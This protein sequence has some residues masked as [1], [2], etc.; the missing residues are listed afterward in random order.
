MCPLA[1]HYH[2]KFSATYWQEKI[3]PFLTLIQGT[4][5]HDYFSIF[6][7]ITTIPH[8]HSQISKKFGTFVVHKPVTHNQVCS[9]P[10]KSII[11]WPATGYKPQWH[12]SR[13]Q[14]YRFCL[15]VSSL[16]D[17]A[18]VSL[19]IWKLS[20]DNPQNIAESPCRP[21]VGNLIK[22]SKQFWAHNN[23]HNQPRCSHSLD[24]E[25]FKRVIQ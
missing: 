25:R 22:L 3:P 15:S 23:L 2:F 20:P 6:S 14:D 16:Q 17:E 1:L 10:L 4:L 13:V 5:W 18:C 12:S 7:K 19:I 8:H 21:T 9:K 24:F 11:L